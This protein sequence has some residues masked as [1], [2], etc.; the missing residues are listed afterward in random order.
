MKKHILY[1]MAFMLFIT[2]C[3]RKDEDVSN[4]VVVPHMEIKGQKFITINVGDPMPTDEGATVVDDQPLDG[5]TTV[6][7]AENTVDPATPGIYYMLYQTK[8]KNGYTV[9]AARYIAVTN[10]ADNTDLSGTYV[11]T[12]NGV[13]VKVTRMSRALY[14][15]A[16]MGGAGLSDAL[17]FAVINDTTIA[18]GPQ[19][20]ESIGDVIDVSSTGLSIPDPTTF[21]YA[22]DAPGY[23]TA[24]R[25]F[26]RQ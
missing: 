13:E 21:Q 1:I 2:A 12:A 14:K 22:L 18:G 6:N 23:G 20:S 10:Y 9:G 5:N 3:R 8:T 25:V 16:D 7:A 15:N 4:V 17:Y 26:E 11:R 19:Y 24:V